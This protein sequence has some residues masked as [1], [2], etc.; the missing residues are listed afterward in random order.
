MLTINKLLLEFLLK[1]PILRN[2]ITNT[3]NPA[4]AA[5]KLP[6][7]PANSQITCHIVE[8]GMK[9]SIN[10]PGAL[11]KLSLFL[12]ICYELRAGAHVKSW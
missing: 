2:K 7:A 8:S 4:P 3:S 11:L 5:F 6:V 10:Y 12:L 9:S 1:T